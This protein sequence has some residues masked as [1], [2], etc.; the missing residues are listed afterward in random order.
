VG[1]R[2]RRGWNPENT[3]LIE[4]WG[5]AIDSDSTLQLYCEAMSS[6]ENGEKDGSLS[7]EWWKYK[8]EQDGSLKLYWADGS[9]VIE[10]GCLTRQYCQLRAA[11]GVWVLSM[12]GKLWVVENN[13]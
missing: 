7:W 5:C 2:D 11:L 8:I 4:Q 1:V 12:G 3:I 9:W 13:I 6:D 10:A